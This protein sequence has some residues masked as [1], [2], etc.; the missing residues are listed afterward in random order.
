MLR[1]TL[2]ASAAPLLMIAALT[3]MR[4]WAADAPAAPPA[5]ATPAQSNPNAP[6]VQE[7]VVT[8][9]KRES[10]VQRTAA[11]VDVV[12]TETLSRQ[13]IMDLKDLNAVLPDAQIVPVVNSLQIT[14]RGIGSDF[15]DPRA[16]PGAAA[17]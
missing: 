4:A 17:S 6:T 5:D 7:V 13:Q 16:D 8:V 3:P 1:K 14:I 12:S 9:E 15:I 11:T 2:L 10:T